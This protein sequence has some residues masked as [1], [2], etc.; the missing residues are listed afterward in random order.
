MF[1]KAALV[2]FVIAFIG[3]AAMAA[4]FLLPLFI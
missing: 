1:D 4:C 3:I 2:D